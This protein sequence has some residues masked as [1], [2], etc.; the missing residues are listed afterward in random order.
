MTALYISLKEF[1]TEKAI[2]RDQ[3]PNHLFSA[4]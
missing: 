3:R 2:K 4:A 1:G